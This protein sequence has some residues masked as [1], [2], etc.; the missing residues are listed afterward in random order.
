MRLENLEKL[1]VHELKDLYD[2]E[3]QILDA[4]PKMIEKAKSDR[5][6]NAFEEHLEETRRQVERLETIF[7][8]RDEEPGGETCVAMKGLIKEGEQLIEEDAD[9]DVRDAGMIAA[10]QRIEHYEIAGYGTARTYAR[11]LEEKEAVRLLGE[12]LEEEKSADATLTEI[13]E[14]TVNPRAEAGSSRS[15]ARV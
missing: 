4:L 6:R 15:K 8:D 2:A 5:L 7:Q 13:A 12:T 3:N 9:E 10:A 11:M 1:F 14:N